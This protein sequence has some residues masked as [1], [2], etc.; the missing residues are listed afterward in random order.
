MRLVNIAHGDLIVLAAYRRA[1]DDRHARAQSACSPSSSSCRSWRRSAM[2][3]SAA[4]STARSATTCCRRCWSPSASRSSSRTGCWSCSPPTAAGSRPAPIE[5]ASF[6]IGEGVWIGV[7][8]L[9]QFV[10]AVAVIAG[11]QFAV[12]PHRARPRLPRH[13]GRS[14]GGAADGS[15]QPPHLRAGHGAVARGRR[16][17]RRVPRG[18][19]QFRSGDR[20]GPADLRLRGGDHRRPRQPVGHARRRHHPR[21]RRRRS[22]RRSIRAGSCSPAISPSSSILAVRPEGLFPKV[23]G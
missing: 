6:Q 4:C 20:A 11:L 13:V 19:H 14:V 10:V 16:G 3:C 9:L 12:L 8:P 15:R 22:A 5:V 17:R 1:D 2:R 23:Q 18:P 7:L 21:R